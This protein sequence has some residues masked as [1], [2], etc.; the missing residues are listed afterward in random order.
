VEFRLPT[1]NEDDLLGGSSQVKFLMVES[2]GGDR[3]T[4]HFNLGYAFSGSV[5]PTASTTPLVGT[6]DFPDEL[7]YAAGVEFVVQPRVTV[8]GDIVGRTLRDVG[9]L[10]LANK[11]FQFQP[12]GNPPPPVSSA[13]FEE[14]EPR[15][16]NLNLIYGTAGV[17]INPTGNLLFSASVLFPL[18]DAGLKSRLTTIIGMDYAF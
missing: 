2:S 17:K 11:T 16:G 14:F 5:E 8:I 13:Q 4:H 3:F 10:S 18:T 7:S 6:G 12:G 9:R 1:G 15:P